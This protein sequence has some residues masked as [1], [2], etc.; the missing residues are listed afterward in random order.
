MVSYVDDFTS[1]FW[2]YDDFDV[3]ILFFLEIL[4]VIRVDIAVNWDSTPWTGL[5]A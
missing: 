3:G 4:D 1:A 2:T 5:W